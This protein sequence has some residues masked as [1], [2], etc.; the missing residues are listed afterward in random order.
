MESNESSKKLNFISKIIIS[1]KDFENYILLAAERNSMAISYFKK[2][3]LIFS[4]VISIAY[5]C[6]FI[7][8]VNNIRGYISNNIE[9]INYESGNLE[10]ITRDTVQIENEEALLQ[11]VIIDTGEDVQEEEYKSK[12]NL[13]DR[14]II[15]LKD[16]AIVKN[17]VNN[18][19]T[20]YNYSELSIEKFDKSELMSVL[21]GK[22]IYYLYATLFV[23]TYVFLF[24]FYFTEA[25]ID[26]I[27]LAILGYVV[28]RINRMKLKFS[29]TLNIGIYALTLPI[30]LKLVY[31]IINLLIG[32][33]IKYFDWMYTTISYVYVVVAILMIKADFIDKQMQLMRI[34]ERI[35]EQKEENPIIDEEKNKDEEENEEE[36][37]KQEKDRDDN[38]GNPQDPATQE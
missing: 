33:E 10:I 6:K 36:D 32:I 5:T 25:F 30:I 29:A 14:G 35:E 18:G 17:K 26:A 22:Q 37:K 4:L 1:I 15:L 20:S 11:V 23:A 38:I 28:A 16:K 24:I 31:I 7:N 21:T 13:Y 19:Q 12:L 2:I 3:I 8:I 27:C 34:H 9:E